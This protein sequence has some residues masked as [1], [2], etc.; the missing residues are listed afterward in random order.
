M[1]AVLAILLMLITP[2]LS[3]AHD[4]GLDAYGC[5]NDRKAGGYHCHSGE[6]A[7]MSFASHAEML[8]A[9]DAKKKAA[10]ASPS[11]FTG[12]VMG[13][14]D[15][16]TLT[17][18]TA[19]KQQVKIRLYGISCPERGREY[20]DRAKKATSDAVFGKRVTVQPVDID[21]YD[22]TVAVVLMPGGKSLNEHLVR[23]GL[24]WVYPQNCTR[25]DICA[26]LKK[27]ESGAKTQG[28]GVWT[29]KKQSGQE[30]LILSPFAPNSGGRGSGL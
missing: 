21:R 29:E 12:A 26:P 1:Y 25:E 6:F 14:T 13:I 2:T 27:L 9:D 19:D 11:Q 3:R 18:L 7:G 8:K 30:G 5:H 28:R 20:W 24:A 4:G 15:G 22:R 16:D 17:V 23:E 10:S